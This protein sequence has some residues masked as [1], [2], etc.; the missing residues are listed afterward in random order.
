MQLV[1]SAAGTVKLAALDVGGD[2]SGDDPS[3]AGLQCA[4]CVTAIALLPAPKLLAITA[5]G[6]GFL[7]P[8]PEK[9]AV[10]PSASPPLPPRGPPVT[11][12]S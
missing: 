8:T 4:L 1:C 12:R 10:S 9:V 11:V 5:V 2:D 7:Q 3:H 6:T